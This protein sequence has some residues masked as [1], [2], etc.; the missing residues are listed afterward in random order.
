VPGGRGIPGACLPHPSTGRGYRAGMSPSRAL[1]ASVLAVAAALLTACAPGS[2]APPA[3]SAPPSAS[4][5]PAPTA[6]VSATPTP[7]TSPTP[8]RVVA[9]PTD[10]RA[11]LSPEVVAQFG[12]LPLND[13][14]F[15]ADAGVQA[16]GGLVCV[17]GRPDTDTGRLTTSIERMNRGPALDLL[18]ELMTQ[19]FTCYTPDGGTRCEKTWQDATYNVASGRTVFWR[20][21]V[22]IDT[23]YINVAVS[24]YTADLVRHVFA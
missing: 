2:D 7:T 24:G 15:G 3:T 12:D 1:A 5:T 11:I 9:L 21:D 8:T 20:E 17:W 4:G 6:S 23:S 22:L 14:A 10:C 19:G 13:P 18:N 16:D